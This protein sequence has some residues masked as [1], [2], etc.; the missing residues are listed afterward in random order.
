MAT[1]TERYK[2]HID[3][4]KWYEVNGVLYPGTA[5][6]HEHIRGFPI[7]SDD[8]TV[9]CYPKSGTH[10]VERILHYLTSEEALDKVQHHT[11][12]P[13]EV[14][15]PHL[16]KTQLEVLRESPSPRIITTHL[17]FELCPRES[18]E[19]KGKIIL[20]IRNPKDV[21]VSHY[22]FHQ[23]VNPKAWS[24][25]A[26]DDFLQVFSDPDTL[27]YGSWFNH[28]KKWLEHRNDSNLLIVK[29][30]DLKRD[31]TNGVSRIADFVG[32]PISGDLASAI[33]AKCQFDNVKKEGQSEKPEQGNVG[34]SLYLRKGQVGDWKSHFTVAQN[35]MFDEVY[36][37]EMGDTELAIQ[38][39]T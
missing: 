35:E 30:E 12:I 32:R 20:V 33:A 13:I 8:I 26:W 27:P 1:A 7:K 22:L 9:V 24:N 39:E 25:F 10:W 15:V 21:V 17:P 2:S 5:E 14:I 34:I 11:S 28:V 19:G 3:K 36:Q 16:P 37:R 6:R 31:L 23:K 38:F 18:Q 4:T 29:F